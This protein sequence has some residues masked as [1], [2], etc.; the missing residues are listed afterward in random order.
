[1]CRAFD[2]ARYVTNVPQPSDLTPPTGPFPLARSQSVQSI[3][4][5]LLSKPTPSI[6]HSR[7]VILEYVLAREGKLR[8][9]KPGR[10]GKGTLS[11]EGFEEI[12]K[13]L[14]EIEDGLKGV[15]AT[16]PRRGTFSRHDSIQDGSSESPYP[17]PLSPPAN[18]DE[19]R[20][21]GLTLILSLR[22]SLSYFTLQGLAEQLLVLAT[23]D[24]E[25]TLVQHIRRRVQ[26]E[27]RFGVGKELEYLEIL[28]GS[29]RLSCAKCQD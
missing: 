2:R 4:H 8:E 23:P 16:S 25:R 14:S 7:E 19:A 12:S 6:L 26:S 22:L 5:H 10:G 13:R 18:L 11:R 27:G 29:H 20:T 15:Q 17:S 24:A 9:K 3:L 28:V 1:M 21:I